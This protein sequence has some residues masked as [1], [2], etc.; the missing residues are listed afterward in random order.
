MND[1]RFVLSGISVAA[2]A[3]SCTA[4]AQECDTTPPAG[5]ISQNDDGVCLSGDG[6]TAADPN[7]GCVV[8][9][10]YLQ[11]IGTLAA[12]QTSIYGNVGSQPDGTL[13]D[14]D[15]Y[16][17]NVAT[18]G[19]MTVD[20]VQNN[21][22]DGDIPTNGL[23]L[24]WG[25]GSA[26]CSEYA[27]VFAF[28]NIGCGNAGTDVVLAPGLHYVL[29]EMYPPAN[30]D[31]SD[32]TTSYVVTL[33]WAEASFDCGDPASGACTEANGLPGCADFACCEK[34]CSLDSVCCDSG[35]DAT[36]VTYAYDLCG[37]YQYECEAP[38]AAND[39]VADAIAHS[40]ADGEYLGIEFD[41]TGCNTDGPPQT[42]CG[43]GAGFEQLHADVW[44]AITPDVDGFLTMT[45]CDGG[46]EWDTKIAAYA[47]TTDGSTLPENFIACN[48]DCGD[49]FFASELQIQVVG[50]VTILLRIGGYDISEGSGTCTVSL[51]SPPSYECN[52]EP[53]N[54]VVTQNADMVAAFGGVSCAY[55][56]TG[57]TTS[58]RFAR[59][60]M[61]RPDESIGCSTFGL[62][63]SGS[64]MLAE[65]NIIE[66]TTTADAPSVLGFNVIQTLP[67]FIPGAGY[68]GDVV[69]SYD[70]MLD[71]I[72]GMNIV[73][74][75]S[76]PESG[77]GFVSSGCNDLGE[78]GLTYLYSEPCGLTDYVS[79][80]A[81]GFSGYHW[82]NSYTTWD[83]GGGT[84]CVGD[85]NDDGVVNGAD[86]TILLGA[87]GTADPVADLNDDGIVNGADLTMLLGAWGAC[88]TP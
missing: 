73:T 77:D 38:V 87:W 12:G 75:I 69:V 8:D 68:L 52:P 88:A 29:V 41:T 18:N 20:Y 56:D 33:T 40:V 49:A 76:I 53:T 14:Y 11:D 43:S 81:I 21:V 66:D 64:G 16:M 2:L 26:D 4:F 25:T 54:E 60:Y 10:T 19:L 6:G 84:T 30:P 3:L 61:N 32:C 44:Y 86:L 48:E 15:W 35:W 63:N 28:Y 78:T 72:A 82:T 50:G 24:L 85:L 5:A 47:F 74:E 39:C 59:K 1:C 79:Y 31:V 65:Y 22:T 13:A 70:A 37:Y 46:A 27:W 71:V 80:E 57:F 55:G 34:V 83:G 23:A 36:C 7:A 58:N 45:T 42:E 67:V 62:T 9:A 51:V 17:F